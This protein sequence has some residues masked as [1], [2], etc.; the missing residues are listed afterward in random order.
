MTPSQSIA[1]DGASPL[2]TC[3]TR[4]GSVK[5]FAPSKDAMDYA[6]YTQDASDNLFNAMA[7]PIERLARL[8]GR[9]FDDAA[10]MIHN[11]VGGY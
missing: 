8:S 7:R 5:P 6:A 3:S 1:Q 11:C 9:S 4:E 2:A 10:I